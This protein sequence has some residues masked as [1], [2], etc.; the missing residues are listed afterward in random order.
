LPAI[1]L[2]HALGG[3]GP[4]NSFFFDNL[5]FLKENGVKSLLLKCFQIRPLTYLAIALISPFVL[6][7]IAALVSWFIHNTHLDLSGLLVAKEFPQWSFLTF[8]IYTLL[9]FGFGEEVGWRGFALRRCQISQMHIDD[10][11]NRTG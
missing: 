7:F 1:L 8:F 2:N 6:A 11:K 9:C 10:S 5:D 3:S 4:I